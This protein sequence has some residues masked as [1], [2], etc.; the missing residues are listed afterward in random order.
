M[1]SAMDVANYFLS[2][3]SEDD[4]ELISNMKLQK[5]LYYAQGF[6]L[7]LRGDSL[8]GDRI[9]AWTHGPVV[10]S[11]YHAF[12]HS[13]GGPVVPEEDIDW[14]AYSPDDRVL[15]DEVYQVYGQYSASAL[16]AL[17]HSEPPWCDTPEGAEITCSAMKEFFETQILDG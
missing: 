9:E 4:G 10:P 5:L 16:R 11:V 3:A 8:F 12:K 2:I 1:L 13:Q 15:L 7:A 17:T 6:A 14:D